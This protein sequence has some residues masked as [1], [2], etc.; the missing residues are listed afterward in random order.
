MKQGA[1]GSIEKEIL[2]LANRFHFF[3]AAAG[4]QGSHYEQAGTGYLPCIPSPR[5][6]TE[7]E[8]YEWLSPHE[9]R[10]A[11]PRICRV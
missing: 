2:N 8:S 10:G 9:A 4:L 11:A 7:G 5:P 3:A 6:P 1:R